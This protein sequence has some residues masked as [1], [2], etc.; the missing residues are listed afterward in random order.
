MR[1]RY[2]LKGMLVAIVKRV[3]SYG[4]LFFRH[5]AIILDYK[6]EVKHLDFGRCLFHG[7]QSSLQIFLSPLKPMQP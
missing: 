5:L 3:K 2:Q 4:G 1:F 6:A 7:W